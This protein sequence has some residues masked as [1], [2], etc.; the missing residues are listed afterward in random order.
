MSEPVA[1]PRYYGEPGNAFDVDEW[2]AMRSE[3][4][5]RVNRR[6]FRL[7]LT[8]NFDHPGAFE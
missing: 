6:A 8:T 1:R 7:S 5:T 2:M 4:M 3:T